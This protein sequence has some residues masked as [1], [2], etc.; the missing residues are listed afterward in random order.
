MEIVRGLLGISVLSAALLA[1]APGL[2]ADDS[3]EPTTAKF[4]HDC[5]K[6]ANRSS[7][8]DLLSEL[9]LNSDITCVPTLDQ[10]LAE[11]E[12]HPEWSSQPWTDGVTTAVKNI[13]SGQ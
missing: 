3:S 8:A 6:Q 11:I 12:K 5:K 2:A 4:L 13:C 1:A 7:C 10:V 9:V